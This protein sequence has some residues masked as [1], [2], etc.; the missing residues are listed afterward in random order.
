MN[1]S[2]KNLVLIV[3]GIVV[4]ISVV[5]MVMFIGVYNFG[6]SS[7]QRLE[8]KLKDNKVV[9]A[10]YHK[11][12]AEAVQVPA[13]ARDD[14][15]KVVTAAIQGRYGEGGSKAVFQ[16]ITEQNPSID[17]SLYSKIQQ[18]IE[19]GRDKFENNQKEM[20]DIERAYRTTLGSF[21]KGIILNIL[22][23][24]RVDLNKFK[25]IVDSST[26]EAFDTGKEEVMILRPK[27]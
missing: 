15:V 3:A 23:Y 6:N 12:V 14:L 10:N 7:E 11:K 16:M 19:S 2:S 21:P 25:I 18:I 1:Q 27:E 4:S 8:A 22:G 20:I 26:E 17:P 5:I 9:L 13:M 24:P